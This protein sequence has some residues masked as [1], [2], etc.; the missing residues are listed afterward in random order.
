[1]INAL[2]KLG[3]VHTKTYRIYEK[4]LVPAERRA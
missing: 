2:K 1:M 3:L 4:A